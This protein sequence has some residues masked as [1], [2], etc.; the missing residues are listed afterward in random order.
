MEKGDLVKIKFDSLVTQD[1]SA[2][3]WKEIHSV[4]TITAVPFNNEGRVQLTA[5]GYGAKDNYG[6]GCLYVRQR[7]LLLVEEEATEDKLEV[8]KENLVKIQILI[9]DTLL[10]LN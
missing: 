1:Y 2:F 6:N 7:D 10:L 8:I 3:K 4:F 5:P 9:R